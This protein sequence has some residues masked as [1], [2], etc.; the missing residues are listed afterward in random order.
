[1]NDHTT[2]FIKVIRTT[3]KQT[4]RLAN[5]VGTDCQLALITCIVIVTIQINQT[6]SI[7]RT[8]FVIIQ[9][10]INVED[11]GAS[12]HATIIIKQICIGFHKVIGFA[13]IIAS[14]NNLVLAIDIVVITINLN[15]TCISFL[16]KFIIVHLAVFQ[17]NAV[18][19]SVIITECIR[20]RSQQAIVLG[21]IV[22]ALDC[23]VAGFEVIVVS[24]NIL[25]TVL[26]DTVYQIIQIALP[27]QQTGIVQS[28]DH[29]TI[30][31]EVIPYVLMAVGFVNRIPALVAVVV[32]EVVSL[33]FDYLPSLI[34]ICRT[35]GIHG[36]LGFMDPNTCGQAAI[37]FEG[38]LQAT[39]GLLSGHSIVIAGKIVPLIVNHIP[40]GLQDTI[41]CTAIGI[42]LSIVEDAGVHGLTDVDAVCTKV[43]VVTVDL[44][45]AGIPFAVVIVSEAAVLSDPAIAQDIDQ[46]IAVLE[47]M[48]NITE[49]CTRLGRIIGVHE[50]FQIE[51]CLV[52]RFLRK[53]VQT[54][55]TQIDLV[56][57]LTAVCNS[58]TTLIGPCCVI[59]GG[60]LDTTEDTHGVGFRRIDRL[61][62]LLPIQRYLQGVGFRIQG[63]VLKLE[64]LVYQGQ[65]AVIH[66]HIGIEGNSGSNFR[67]GTDTLCQRHQECPRRC[68]FHVR[69]RQHV[70]QIIQLAGDGNL[71]H[72]DR[73]DIGSN[74]ILTGILDIIGIGIFRSCVGN[75]TI[76]SQLTVA[77]G[78]LVKVEG[79]LTLVVHCQRDACAHSSIMCQFNRKLCSL[80]G[81]IFIAVELEIIN[82]TCFRLLQC[83]YQIAFHNG[84][85]LAVIQR[86]HRQ[87]N[88]V[89]I[90]QVDLTLGEV[91]VVGHHDIHNLAADHLALMDQADF[92]TTGL[93][94]GKD[95]VRGNFTVL[96]A[97]NIPG[98]TLGNLCLVTGCADTLSSD[99]LG[100][101]DGHIVGFGGQN[102]MVK[103]SGAGSSGNHEQRGTDR[104]CRTVRRSVHNFQFCAA[105]RLC[106]KCSGTTAVQVDGRLTAS[107]HHDLCNFLHATAAG[108]GLLSA[109]QNHQNDLAGLG[110]T[111]S[112]AARPGAVVR[113]DNLTIP[114]QIAKSCNCIANLSLVGGFV[115]LCRTNNGS[116]IL[117]NAKETLVIHGM[118]FY[119]I[120]HYQYAARL[121]GTHI[122][123]GTVD[124]G[125]NIIVFNVMLAFRITILLLC[126]VCLIQN[127]GHCMDSRIVVGIVCE[128]I[129]IASVYIDSCDI[130][131]H[132]LVIC[133]CCVLDVLSNARCQSRRF[134]GEDLVVGVLRHVYKV[135]RHTAQIVCNCIAAGLLQI[136]QITGGEFS[137]IFQCL[138]H[139]VAGVG[140][141]H[142]F[143]NLFTQS[144]A[145]QSVL[146]QVVCTIFVCQTFGEVTAQQ[147][148]QSAIVV[149]HR[150]QLMHD[151]VTVQ[152]TLHIRQT[153]AALVRLG[154]EGTVRLQQIVCSQICHHFLD[155]SGHTELVCQAQQVNRIT[156]PA[157]NVHMV[158]A[159]AVVIGDVHHTEDMAH[160]CSIAVGQF[161]VLQ[162]LQTADGQHFFAV[163]QGAVICV[164]HGVD[165]FCKCGIFITGHNTPG[166]GVIALNT[167]T[168]V[169]D[170]QR[171]R[172]LTGIFQHI[173]VSNLFQLCQSGNKGIIVVDLQCTQSGDLYLGGVC[174]AGTSLICIPA[175]T[176]VSS[177]LCFKLVDV[178]TQSRNDFLRNQH[179]ITDGTMR[180]LCQTGIF[181]QSHSVF[182]LDLG[183]TQSLA[184]CITTALVLTGRRS[185]TAGFC[186][187]VSGCGNFFLSSQ[188]LVTDRAVLTFCQTGGITLGSNCCIDHFGMTQCI[189]NFLL[190]QD[191][192][193]DGAVFAFRQTGCLTGRS[194]SLIGNLLVLQCSDFL[195][196]GVHTILTGLVCIPASNTTGRFLSLVIH[197]FMAQSCL[198]FISVV[199]VAAGTLHISI[200]ADIGT[201]RCLGFIGHFVMAQGFLFYISV[202]VAATGTGLIGI[203]ADCGTG[204]CLGNMADY[205]VATGF[206][207]YISVVVFAAGTGLI[208]IPANFGTGGCL[209]YMRHFV[210]AQSCLFFICIVVAAGT[211]HISIPADIQASGGLGFNCHFVMAQSF[212]FCIGRIVTA[213]SGTLLISIPADCG[214]GRC[215]SC[216]RL[217]SMIKGSTLRINHVIAAATGFIYKPANFGTGRCFGSVVHFVMT[218]SSLDYIITA[219]TGTDLGVHTGSFCAG[220]I[221]A[222]FLLNHVVT[223]NPGTNLIGFTGSRCTGLVMAQ[224]T[225]RG[226]YTRDFFSTYGAVDN[227]IVAAISSTGCS[228]FVFLHC[229]AIGMTQ[230][231]YSGGYARD[232]FLT[233]STVDNRIVA[234]ISSTGCSHIVL[235]H[236]FAIGMT[237]GAYSGGYARDFFLTDS[238]VDNRIVAAVGG[239]GCSNV[240]FLHCFALGMA[241]SGN[242]LVFAALL[243]I[244]NGA[245]YDAVIAAI[246]SAGCINL[247]FYHSFRVLVALGSDAVTYIAVTA[248]LSGTGVGGVTI[249]STGVRGYNCLVIVAKRRSGGHHGTASDHSV[250]G[251]AAGTSA[252]CRLGTGRR[253]VVKG[254]YLIRGM[255]SGIAILLE[256]FGF[257]FAGPAVVS[258]EGSNI[259]ELTDLLTVC[260]LLDLFLNLVSRNRLGMICVL[261]DPGSSTLGE[262]CIPLIGNFCI[263]VMLQSRD[264]G[265]SRQG[266]TTGR[267]LLTGSRTVC[268]AGCGY[269]RNLHLSMAQ[270]IHR[271][272]VGMTTAA[273]SK[274]LHTCCSAGG[275]RS[276]NTL[277][278]AMAKN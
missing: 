144:N 161:E 75:L 48:V 67:Q 257:R 183:M 205:I 275:F 191:L 104:T 118:V 149:L 28:F 47:G 92:N 103:C 98:C 204:R 270:R 93:L 3:G 260:F 18:L 23:S 45:D 264:H 213:V 87:F 68:A 168:D 199:V 157:A 228:N 151:V 44:V 200:P 159:E 158:Q 27:L 203:P 15:Q 206:L 226:R 106:N 237:Q 4:I 231:A 88:H 110:D 247:I 223:A 277:V 70:D 258:G 96:R 214:T 143:T 101:A 131:D 164:F 95:T 26:A 42:C 35:I 33:A 178:M 194:N 113:C 209:C 82:R 171:R 55:C 252:L 117:Q 273:A 172:I 182:V 141:I 84:D 147:T 146:Q 227:C 221:M 210:M 89:A 34:V 29:G 167:G 249:L 235:N 189:N 64:E 132:L 165:V 86:L 150:L 263:P 16:A 12:D 1:M 74:H 152:V 22:V 232:F 114:N 25:Q 220:R 50:G 242:H 186:H 8:I 192:I 162:V 80:D 107:F 236:C 65:T 169:L 224:S 246:N 129:H 41:L 198:F 31:A 238:T 14:G 216:Y 274:G 32:L 69:A 244:T 153:E 174:T 77:A 79:C 187:L 40:A 253:C 245:V 173:V 185:G 21:D 38:V 43:V 105:F 78:C 254:F 85:R 116:T 262:I 255:H 212:L 62:L 137:G 30:V 271:F 73:K 61:S 54:A 256:H 121:A 201:G 211:F 179:L 175:R 190:H 208:G 234:A 6:S 184:F 51:G 136:C 269:L 81:A 123:A 9:R 46:G 108:E 49:G 243:G 91:N 36:A 71:G 37:V 138:D 76:P 140:I 135:A 233:D 63:C 265:R 193:T 145:A 119:T 125:N 60:Q 59:L 127:A 267:A 278:I 180:A 148:G 215:R 250:T 130:E 122:I 163:S 166:T 240:V 124:T 133:G 276:Y 268:G 10:T 225:N 218:Q 100:T 266:F 115:F 24:V 219:G 128:N 66:I 181:T 207:F 156:D 97:G 53:G 239:T 229:F 90:D 222:Q 154:G 142:R 197:Q 176:G 109:V 99:L 202:V 248:V 241:G 111:N 102:C 57:D 134:T 58:Q 177:L 261:A 5:V 120:M 259:A 272:G 196:G 20:A 251:C 139:L 72:V 126:K 230:G 39:D 112:R 7:L 94:G 170:D 160:V 19:H 11:T 188:D 83:E 56:A 2:H 195:I 17:I 217:D 13:Y 52:L 155:G